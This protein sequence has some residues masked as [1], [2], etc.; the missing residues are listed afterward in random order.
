MARPRAGQGTIQAVSAWRCVTARSTVY[1]PTA[2]RASSITIQTFRKEPR[3][4]AIRFLPVA[5]CFTR[6]IAQQPVSE[7]I[8][9]GLFHRPIVQVALS[10]P[11][12]AAAR[13]LAARG[14]RRSS[15]HHA[16]H[17]PALLFERL[18]DADIPN[19]PPIPE[20]VLF[21]DGSFTRYR[22]PLRADVP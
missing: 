5:R 1:P 13:V 18:S 7:S 11:H 8:L 6:K 14:A 3:S 10:T 4:T 19:K 16:A 9:V 12:S 15:N 22:V 17:R 21:D 20:W 2:R